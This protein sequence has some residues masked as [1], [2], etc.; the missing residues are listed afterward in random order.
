MSK[1]AGKRTFGYGNIP[2]P[3]GTPRKQKRCSSPERTSAGMC[4]TT[5]KKIMKNIE[6]NLSLHE[7][8]YEDS[9]SP[10]KLI[11]Y[12]RENISKLDKGGMKKKTTVG[13]FGKTGAGKSSLINTILGEKHLL[14]SGTLCACTSVIIQVGANITDSNYTAEIEFISKEE[15]EEELKTLLNVLREDGEEKD[16][17]MCKTATEKITALY[18]EECVNMRVE[19]LMKDDK[20]SGIPEF[21]G[22]ETKKITSK[23][24]SDL[25]DEIR[26]YVQHDDSSPGECYWP[27][28]KSVTIKVPNCED[29]LE[30]VLLVDLPGTGDC[31]K[32]R[33]QMWRSKLRECST[34]WIVSE[35]N[36]AGSEQE[37]WELVCNSVR[38]MAQA[39]ECRSMSFICTKTDQ[40]ETEKYMRSAKLKDKDFQITPKDSQYN[41]KR[42]SKCILHRNNKAKELVQKSFKQLS[43]F[44]KHFNCD[45]NFLSVFTVSSKE[46][47]K[48]RSILTP[49]ETEIPKL[50]EVLMKYNNSHTN[51]TTSQYFSGALG[52]LSLI[53][54]INASDTEMMRNRLHEKFER[55]LNNEL[56]R[57]QEYTGQI[58]SQLDQLLSKGAEESEKNCVASAEEL[59]KPK[60]TDGRGFHQSL[61]ALC[62]NDGAY[63]SK[64][65]ETDLNTHLVKPMLQHVDTPFNEFFQVQENVT[66]K[67]VQT[68][69]N[70]FTIIPEHM[71][72]I[73]QDSPVL[74]HLLKFLKTEEMK[75][76]TALK[77]D[78]VEQKKEIY[79]SLSESIKTTMLPC[80]RR[81][82]TKSGKGSMKEKQ[83][84]LLHHIKL[85]KSKMFQKAKKKMLEELRTTLNYTVEEI[86]TGLTESMEYSLL[87]TSTLP[88]MDVSKEIEIMED[89]K[90]SSAQV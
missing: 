16:V 79:T 19:D 53:Q 14:P 48:K 27:V 32:T 89:L 29:F 73:Y 1:R 38:H 12:I 5:A 77:Q 39:G 71:I 6:F 9:S 42:K 11:Q 46:F 78:I 65:G 85:S 52:I 66:D 80:Y 60:G 68:N 57:L 26:C 83:E 76:K 8:Q 36:R 17:A 33:D 31:N 64:K 10:K 7:K 67:S 56:E 34:V 63:R 58:Y 81:A 43:T 51:Q 3:H 30:H 62:K 13:V 45:D 50:R 84:I 24:A 44:K 54:G 69:I 75:L 23:Q 41:V 15:W 55:N 40:I 47:T 21:L 25:S 87:N 22:S 37:A 70:N 61:T 4:I 59:V 18:G 88:D 72:K 28:V 20:F 35:M 49:D 82:A 90:G 86:R 74:S 2:T